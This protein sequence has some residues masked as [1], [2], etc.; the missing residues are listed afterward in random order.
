MSDSKLSI[1]YLENVIQINDINASNLKFIQG[2]KSN[3]Q[4]QLN[5]QAIA[6]NK[7]NSSFKSLSMTKPDVN[8][9]NLS[10]KNL[11]VTSINSIDI[12]DFFQEKNV[13]YYDFTVQNNIQTN[14][15]SCSNTITGIA[16]IFE[17]VGVTETLESNVARIVN[18]ETSSCKSQTAQMDHID[19]ET[20]FVKGIPISNYFS[21]NG[22]GTG[23][24]NNINLSFITLT[25]SND[26]TLI[27]NTESSL[28]L[29]NVD[30]Y[31]DTC[32]CY[33]SFECVDNDLYCRSGYFTDMVITGYSDDRLKTV[34]EEL[35]DDETHK[36][37]TL[38]CFKYMP[39]VEKFCEHNI[40]L[41]CDRIRYGLS[42]QQVREIFP[43]IVF[44]SPIH[45]EFLTIHYESLIPII[46][47]E[48]KHINAK[49]STL[50]NHFTFA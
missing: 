29:K 23:W 3:I 2:C 6:L 25:G 26:T 48:I 13:S 47:Q 36:L 34:I 20:L 11:S 15:L 18:L 4:N 24:S 17:R 37:N 9:V 45:E 22:G 19:C 46:I 27:T 16:G 39:N 41:H 43:E 30:I 5:L 44:S 42:A 32:Q 38:S 1:N 28:T 49:L 35:D 33:G 10:V 8:I 7:L 31:G 50:M 21:E 14:T 12:N 40:S